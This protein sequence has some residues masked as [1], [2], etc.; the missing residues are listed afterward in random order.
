MIAFAVEARDGCLVSRTI[1]PIVVR[2]ATFKAPPFSSAI[3]SYMTVFPTPE[4]LDDLELE[5]PLHTMM[6]I[7]K[8]NP[9]LNKSVKVPFFV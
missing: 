4:T 3:R 9:I 8:K 1:F 2:T 7:V 6:L 5:M